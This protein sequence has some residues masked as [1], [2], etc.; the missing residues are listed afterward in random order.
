MERLK[1][2]SNQ[3][4]LVKSGINNTFSFFLPT[5]QI[6]LKED[7]TFFGEIRDGLSLILIKILQRSNHMPT[8]SS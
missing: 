1:E 3:R 6:L 7:N 2:F 8:Q 4:F 5:F